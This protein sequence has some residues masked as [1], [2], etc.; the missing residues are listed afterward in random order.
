MYLERN[1]HVFCVRQYGKTSE[2]T[3]RCLGICRK[4]KMAAIN[5]KYIRN[6]SVSIYDSNEIQT[7]IPMFSGTGDCPTCGLYKESKMAPIILQLTH[8]IC[9]S[10]LI[11]TS[12]SLHSNLVL[13]PDLDPQRM[14]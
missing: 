12:G 13:L 7:A 14:G 5:R 8:A 2:D 6:I 10:Q 3:V 9:K 4:S 11:D 1:T